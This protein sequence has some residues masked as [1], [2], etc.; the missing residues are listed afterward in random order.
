MNENNNVISFLWLYETSSCVVVF[1]VPLLCDQISVNVTHRAFRGTA[2]LW[3]KCER[4]HTNILDIKHD[5]GPP[6]WFCAS[7]FDSLCLND[8][9]ACFSSAYKFCWFIRLAECSAPIPLW[10]ILQDPV[11]WFGSFFLFLADFVD[12]HYNEGEGGSEFSHVLAQ[13]SG[14]VCGAR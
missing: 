9:V 2:V 6:L 11:W 1:F 12:S 13:I 8:E 7:P 5:R 10:D 4:H 14:V 3:T